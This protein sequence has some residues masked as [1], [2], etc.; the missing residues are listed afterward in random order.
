MASYDIWLSLTYFILH[1]AF[2]VHLCCCKWQNFI[3]YG[4]V[5]F[6][7]GIVVVFQCRRPAF[8]PLVVKIPWRRK[9]LPTPVFL[10]G[11]LHEQRSLVGYIWWGH[12][13]SDTTKQLT[14]SLLVFHC[15]CMDEWMDGWIY[16]CVYVCVYTTTT[17]SIHLLMDI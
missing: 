15:T 10:P 8:N 17:L 11:K 1:N 7:C 12:K 3:F 4:L 9:W 14:F 5:V 6:H 16:M 13:E 2:Q